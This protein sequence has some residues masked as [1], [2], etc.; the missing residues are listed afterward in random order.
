M[1]CKNS[2]GIFVHATPFKYGKYGRSIEKSP[3][4]D[5]HIGMWSFPLRFA[6][7]ADEYWVLLQVSTV[8]E[9]GSGL[10][11]EYDEVYAVPQ[12]STMPAWSW[13]TE[14]GHLSKLQKTK[15]VFIHLFSKTFWF[16]LLQYSCNL[17]IL[18][19]GGDALH[20][21]SDSSYSFSTQKHD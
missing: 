10:L 2:Q 18:E 19:G 15:V 9:S 6:W 13:G 14:M 21:D 7:S 3:I 17:I 16:P 8:L 1:A 12:R 4:R 11:R 5:V 20:C